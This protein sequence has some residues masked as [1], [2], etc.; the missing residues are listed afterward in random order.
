MTTLEL[1]QYYASLLIFQYLSKPNAVAT[2]ESSVE[3]MIMPQTS[4]QTIAFSGI[5]ISGSFS[6]SYNSVVT[7]VIWNASASTI[8]A[9]LQGISL[10]ESVTVAG[11]IADQL[12]TVTFIG[13]I[14]P[15]LSLVN[16]FNSLVDSSSKSVQI[17]I[18]ETDLTLPIAI[19]NAFNLIG[20]QPA[21]GVQLDILGKYAGV[22]RTGTGLQGQTIVLSDSDFLVLIQMAII[23]NSNGSS[24]YDIVTLLFEFF[25]SEILVFDSTFMSMTY[26]ISSVASS[27]LVQLFVTENLLPHPMG[28]GVVVIY[29]PIINAFFGFITYD[30][31]V[32]PASTRP[33]NDYDAYQTDWPWLSYSDSFHL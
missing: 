19:Q 27:N 24:L 10:L 16:T 20:P 18:T 6:L 17:T 29:A 14:P 26:L 7:S 32:Q 25:G 4:V 31:P 5:P 23:Q 33:F 2:I 15:A 30:N 11:S 9:Q 21:E 12:L 13:V 28:V 8:Q 22:S 3:G 1:V